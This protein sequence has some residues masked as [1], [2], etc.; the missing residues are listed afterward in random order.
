MSLRSAHMGVLTG[1][2]A[3][4]DC[5]VKARP[6]WRLSVIESEV[7]FLDG[8]A[9]SARLAS[10]S[11]GSLALVE[12]RSFRATVFRV[13]SSSAPHVNPSVARPR[14]CSGHGAIELFDLAPSRWQRIAV[15]D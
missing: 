15:A 11:G 5:G 2:G 10:A 14:R 6:R 4:I 13:L 3:A 8:S 12:T 7:L 1:M 9:T